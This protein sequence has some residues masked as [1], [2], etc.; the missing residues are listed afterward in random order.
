MPPNENI[1]CY[2]IL[3]RKVELK[4]H[5]FPNEPSHFNKFCVPCFRISENAFQ[6]EFKWLGVTE[7]ENE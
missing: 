7:L 1:L 6:E 3:P 2:V 4:I 5:C